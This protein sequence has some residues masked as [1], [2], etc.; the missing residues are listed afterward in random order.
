MSRKKYMTNIFLSILTW[1]S[2]CDS[3]T[4][5]GHHPNP[6]LLPVFAD[7]LQKNPPGVKSR[8]LGQTLTTNFLWIPVLF[9]LLIECLEMIDLSICD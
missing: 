4:T 7:L 8:K 2:E 1:A 9:I 5:I 3:Q 6:K